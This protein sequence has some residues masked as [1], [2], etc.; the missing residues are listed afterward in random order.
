MG[1]RPEA[2]LTIEALAVAPKVSC[3]SGLV[4]L[5]VAAGDQLP[6]LL[7]KPSMAPVQV[8]A[9]AGAAAAS[10][11]A[12]AR[13]TPAEWFLRMTCSTGSYPGRRPPR[14][15]PRRRAASRPVAAVPASTNADG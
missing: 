6:G 7:Q 11:T 14:P 2:L 3:V 13:R 8:W 5:G 10:P 12:R 1:R 4:K 9:A 15:P